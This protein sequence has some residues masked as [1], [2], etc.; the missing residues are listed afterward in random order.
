[1][2]RMPGAE[3]L[4]EHSPMVPMNRYDIVCVHTI[5]GYA[6]AHATGGVD[7]VY[8]GAFDLRDVIT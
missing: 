3:W 8:Q 6:P 2:A 7:R 5:V 4:G 1:M